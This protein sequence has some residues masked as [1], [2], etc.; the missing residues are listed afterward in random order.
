MSEYR[1]I[2]EQTV[3]PGASVIFSNDG[4]PCGNGSIIHQDESSVFIARGVVKNPYAAIGR[5]QVDFGANVA[6]PTGGTVEE[7]TL[8]V[9]VGGAV[10]P[11]STIRIT[12]TAVNVYENV[13]RSIEVPIY[14]GVPQYISITNTS[15]QPIILTNSII[16][17]VRVA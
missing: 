10:E 15:S 6:I 8:A 13:S 14:R 4:F 16:D 17:L 11:A 1:F 7:I 5:L 3:A 12:P 2:N 9:S